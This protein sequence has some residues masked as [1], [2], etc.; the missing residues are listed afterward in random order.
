MTLLLGTTSVKWNFTKFLFDAD[1]NPVARY[2]PTTSPAD[3]EPDIRRLLQG[4]K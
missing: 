2:A 4:R 3:M 1:G